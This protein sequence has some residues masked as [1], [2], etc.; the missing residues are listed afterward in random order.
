MLD[1]CGRKDFL[2]QRKEK[3]LSNKKQPTTNTVEEIHPQPI[4]L[5]YVPTPN[6]E[7]A[8]DWLDEDL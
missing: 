6:L 3:N 7:L 4:E 1:I 5:E 2:I 8:S